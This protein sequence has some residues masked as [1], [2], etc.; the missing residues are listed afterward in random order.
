MI[1]LHFHDFVCFFSWQIVFEGV[2]GKSYQGDIAIDD[3]KL[4][5]GLCPYP[6]DYG[7]FYFNLNDSV[8]HIHFDVVSEK[9]LS[10]PL[11]KKRLNSPSQPHLCFCLYAR[12]WLLCFSK[13]SAPTIAFLAF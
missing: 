4:V 9:F 1:T 3:L 2:V 8:Y 12:V 7:F 6:G 10:T 11:D 13:F 5:K